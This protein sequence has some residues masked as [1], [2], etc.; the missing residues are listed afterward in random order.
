MRAL[1][2]LHNEIGF[3]NWI[4]VLAD[5]NG[6][7]FERVEIRRAGCLIPRHLSDEFE[8]YAFFG[9]SDAYFASIRAGRRAD[10]FVN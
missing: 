5:Q 7:L 6:K 4:T 1:Q 2:I 9:K 10:D 8:W 3:V